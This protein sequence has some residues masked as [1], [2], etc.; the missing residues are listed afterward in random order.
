MENKVNEKST[1]LKISEVRQLL[2]GHKREQLEYVA[3]ELYKMLN[4]SQKLEKNV[5]SLLRK[6]GSFEK[7]AQTKQAKGIRPF[8]EIEMET[9]SFIANA[10][11]QNYLVPNRSVS[12]KDRPKWRFLVKKVFK[13]LKSYMK[14]PEYQAEVAELLEKLYGVLCYSC[15]YQLFT[16]YDTFES[17]GI[18]QTEFFDT[19][20]KAVEEVTDK[21]AF[22]E[23]GIDLLLNNE[24]NR[25]TLRS[26]LMDVFIRHLE[27]T[28]M[29]YLLIEKCKAK[30]EAVIKKGPDKKSW[31]GN[32]KHTENLNNLTELVFRSYAGLYEIKNAIGYYKEFYIGKEPEVILYILASLLMQFSE[33]DAILYELQEAEK[34]NIK[35]RP[36]L[37][38][39]K[40]FITE[41]DD[42]PKHL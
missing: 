6:P 28:D 20:L 18:E 19:V 30:R 27:T 34:Q 1:P 36:T 9:E 10:Y 35:L 24:L 29:K 38:S 4:K 8:D 13:E 16:A 33:K 14:Q 7:K 22:I 15:A 37:V 39:L 12:K 26:G 25:Y 5:D 40:D 2:K 42:L 3:C 32:Y 11:E 41:H 17:T 23:K 21:P 31:S